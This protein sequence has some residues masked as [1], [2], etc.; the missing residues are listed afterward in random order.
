MEDNKDLKV[1]GGIMTVAII[2][3]VLYVLGILGEIFLIF[4][5]DKIMDELSKMN[6]ADSFQISI[7]EM[8]ISLLLSVVILASLIL[9]LRKVKL[10]VIMYYACTLVSIICNIILSG[11]SLSGFISSLIFPGLMLIFISKKKEL[12]G[13]GTKVEA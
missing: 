4:S 13:L 5:K 9:I 12:Y 7:G 3:M 6:M 2:Q 11:F 8:A 1:G 10:G